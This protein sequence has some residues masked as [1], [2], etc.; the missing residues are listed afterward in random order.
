MEIDTGVNKSEQ[1]LGMKIEREGQYENWGSIIMGDFS[2][3]I[4]VKNC[5][6]KWITELE[7][8]GMYK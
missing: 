1:S 4:K 2:C 3:V 5:N 6:G 8:K 7:K